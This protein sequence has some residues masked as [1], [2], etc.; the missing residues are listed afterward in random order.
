MGCKYKISGFTIIET[1]L[2]LAITGLLAAGLLVGIGTSINTQRYKDSVIS[3]QAIIQQQFSNVSNVSNNRD[4][5]WKCNSSTLNAKSVTN[6]GDSIGQSNC[7]II[8]KLITVDKIDKSVLLIKTVLGSPKSSNG[9]SVSNKNSLTSLSD[10]YNLS[11]SPVDTHTEKYDIEWGNH[12]TN[13]NGDPSSFS[14]FIFRSPSNGSIKTLVD[15]NN[16]VNDINSIVNESALSKEVKMCLTPE[17]IVTGN[18]MS[19]IV[20]SGATNGNDVETGGSDSGC[21]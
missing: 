11:F 10:Q 9:E 20:K 1:M 18:K 14:I 7:V 16:I 21:K 12:L 19:I 13:L 5:S 6:G 2:F 3:L 8:G 4:G 17:G 15:P